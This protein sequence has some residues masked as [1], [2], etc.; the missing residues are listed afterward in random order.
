MGNDTLGGA[1]AIEILLRGERA[2]A[3]V[4]A[5]EKLDKA[6]RAMEHAK[7]ALLLARPAERAERAAAFAEKEKAAGSA[8][9]AFIVH[10]EAIGLWTHDDV[11]EQ[12][13]VPRGL[14]AK[15]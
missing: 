7:E 14:V 6:C 15:P 12:Y 8:L 13:R 11:Y 1:M 5:A 4:A 2:S 3:V 10:R 9:W